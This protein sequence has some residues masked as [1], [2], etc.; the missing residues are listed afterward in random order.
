MKGLNEKVYS[1]LDAEARFKACVAARARGDEAEML[2]LIKA[3]PQR[4]YRQNEEPFV[5][6]MDAIEEMGLVVLAGVLIAQRDLIESLAALNL[7]CTVQSSLEL[8]VRDHLEAKFSGQ[9][10]PPGTDKMVA[11]AAGKAVCE[12]RAE[13]TWPDSAAA[14]LKDRGEAAAVLAAVSDWCAEIGIPAADFS[15]YNGLLAG[16][17]AH[18]KHILGDS[19]E[20]DEAFR[21]VYLDALRTAWGRLTRNVTAG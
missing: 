10:L 15:R 7:E 2:K 4:D 12:G 11:E 1:S 19:N 18:L 6:R 8:M 14:A 13:G 20:P 16:E 17:L 21:G 3:C 5:S 9:E